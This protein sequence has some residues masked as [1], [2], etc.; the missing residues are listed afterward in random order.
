MA[1]G[2]IH[3]RVTPATRLSPEEVATRGFASS[4]RG[5]SEN[6]VRGFLRRVADEMAYTR[7]RER[8]LEDRIARLEAELRNPPPLTE[9]QLLDSLGEE[10]ARVL[11]SAQEA[12]ED[13]RTKAQERSSVL[14]D[15]AET[16]ARR[17]TEEA[18]ARHDEQLRAAEEAAAEMVRVAERDAAD[19][20][21]AVEALVA[22]EG[23]RATSEAEAEIEVARTTGREMVAEARAVRERILADLAR[24]RTAMQQQI[25]ELRHG[26][27]QLLG[28]YRVV[29]ETL[30][31]ATEALSKVETPTGAAPAL[32]PDTPDVAEIERLLEVEGP[33][34]PEGAS[35]GV[36]EDRQSAPGPFAGSPITEP[37]TT[38]GGPESP[39]PEPA[40]GAPAPAGAVSES[41]MVPAAGP[42]EP[43]AMELGATELGATEL[44]ATELG[45]TEPGVEPAGPETGPAATRDV[46]ALFAKI[47]A[48]R[49]VAV[50]EAREV[51]A[52]STPGG[53]V[54]A[55]TPSGS[56][57]ASTTEPSVDDVQ[58]ASTPST[59]V[60]LVEP[61]GA[62]TEGVQVDLIATRDAALAPIERDLLKLAK[63]LLQDEQNDV[64]DTM[65]KVKGT[66]TSDKVLPE[67]DV[68]VETWSQRLALAIDAAHSA[69]SGGEVD[70]PLELAREL[71]GQFIAPLRERI[72]ATIDTTERGN[73]GDDAERDDTEVAQRVGARYREWK[74][75]DLQGAIGD[76]VV[77]A[78]ARGVADAAPQDSVLQWITVAGGC[79]PDCDDNTL[80][81]TARGNPFPTGQLLP[82][83]HP[84]CRCLIAATQSV[85]GVRS[86]LHAVSS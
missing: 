26:R 56:R 64:L 82:P 51:L 46:N 7:D 6:E 38:I 63:R 53:E 67:L 30:T 24:R 48:A 80:E 1:E 55:S 21:A 58:S 43:G 31:E 11:R 70:A 10:T 23:A 3:R 45:A 85:A 19:M 49:S 28:A 78:Y 2:D 25:D 84:G 44:G 32:P 36:P 40:A 16:E 33:T 65:R 5:V 42:T 22:A 73:D 4:F 60:D 79:C 41:E 17:L 37:V 75:Q 72:A 68:H 86:P 34:G 57:E 14:V 77:A 8:E 66:L 12:A 59:A 50:D 61:I 18:G 83:A 13:I 15:Q 47:R 81:P 71:T 35:A 74:S 29:K 9:Q 54:A 27:E 62:T 76:L 52:E 20:R 69:G 39:S